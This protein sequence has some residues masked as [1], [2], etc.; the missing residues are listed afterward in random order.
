MIFKPSY[1]IEFT[2]WEF[3]I[4]E[5]EVKKLLSYSRIEINYE[6]SKN[7]GL[8][9]VTLHCPANVAFWLASLF[10]FSVNERIINERQ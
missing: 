3:Q 6:V 7:N 2:E 9:C 10:A 1:T 5:Q 4:L 8:Y